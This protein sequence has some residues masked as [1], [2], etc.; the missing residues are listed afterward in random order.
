MAWIILLLVVRF[1][2]ALIGCY[3][4][5]VWGFDLFLTYVQ[6]ADFA[7]TAYFACP[8][9]LTCKEGVAANYQIAVLGTAF[10]IFLI[11]KVI[12]PLWF[13]KKKLLAETPS[14]QE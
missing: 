9:D 12:F 10:A 3:V 7:S 11:T 2:A 5:T 13:V 8:I 1:T 14:E 6:K 4:F